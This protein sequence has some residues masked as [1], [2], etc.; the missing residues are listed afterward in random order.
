[1]TTTHK[2]LGYFSAAYDSPEAHEVTTRYAVLASPRTGSDYICARLANFRGALGIP[3]EYLH[4]DAVVEISTRADRPPDVVPGTE[5]TVAI[6]DYMQILEQLR[7]TADGYFGLKAQPA[8]LLQLAGGKLDQVIDFLREFDKLV[9][10]YRKDKVAQAVSGAVAQ[11]TGRW[12]NFGEKPEISREHGKR[13]FPLMAEYLATYLKQDAL[14]TAIAEALADHPSLVVHYESLIDEPDAVIQ[15]VVSF[16][17]PGQD[18][19]P[20]EHDLVPVTARPAGDTSARFRADFLAH[21]ANAR[22]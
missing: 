14:V 18:T 3:M 7:A 13:L 15:R 12:V 17:K 8:Q 22:G 11:T 6:G 21:I 20:P 5:G 19:L 9:F 1:M 2:S 16:L 10:L 4:A